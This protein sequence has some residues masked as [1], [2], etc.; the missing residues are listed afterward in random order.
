MGANGQY[1]TVLPAMG[2]VLAHKV[3]IDQD[4]ARKITPSEFHT[5]LQ[6]VIDSGCSEGCN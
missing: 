6:M 4:P 2:L 1:I 3:D 5:I